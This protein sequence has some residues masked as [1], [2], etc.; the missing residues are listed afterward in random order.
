MIKSQAHWSFETQCI[1]QLA[2]ELW[3]TQFDF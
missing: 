1:F 2:V 3:S